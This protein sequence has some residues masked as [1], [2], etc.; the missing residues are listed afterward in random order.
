METKDSNGTVLQDGDSVQLI[1]D[2]KVKGT[3]VTLKVGHVIKKIKLID[4]PEA[5]ECKE[6]R[7]V[8]VLKTMYLKK[9][10]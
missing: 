3:S 8:F 7:S 9:R 4:D 1:K 2:L 5:I 10:K 6:G